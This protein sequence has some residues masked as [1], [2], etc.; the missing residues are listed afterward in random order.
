MGGDL[1]L[2]LRVVEGVGFTSE[3]GELEVH[4]GAVLVGERLGHEGGVD[5]VAH[6][7]FLDQQAVGHDGVRHGEG[8]RVAEVHFVLAGGRLV[9]AE[10]DADAHLFEGEHGFASE[11]R[12]AIERGQVEVAALVQRFG[13]GGVLEVEEFDFRRDVEGEADLRGASED[14]LED[15]AWVAFERFAA[16]DLDV[17]EHAGDGL[18]ARAPGEDLEGGGIG[19]DDHVRLVA[20]GEALDRGAVEGDAVGEGVF[21]LLDGD[22]DGLEHAEDVGE[23]ETDELYVVVAT[24][25]EDVL[26]G[27]EVCHGIHG[28]DRGVSEKFRVRQAANL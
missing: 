21:Q 10:G 11:V 9:M 5:A 2:V 16:R 7:H 1:Q 24:C 26:T 4:A 28:S 20:T 14:A 23:P 12:A 3:E 17:A 22:G 18:F 15:P 27:I 8:V 19:H 6:G 25:L 13:A